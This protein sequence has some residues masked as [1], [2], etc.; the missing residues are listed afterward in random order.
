MSTFDAVIFD[1][2]GTLLDTERLFLDAALS[3]LAEQ[4]HDVGREFMLSLVGISDAEGA[5]RLSAR[6]GPRFDAVAFGAGWSLAARRAF[7]GGIPLM[8]GVAEFL[9]RLDGSAHPRAVATNSSTAGACFKLERAG[10]LHR[11][12]EAA[13]VGVDAVPLAKP[14]PDLFLE[15]ARRLDAEPSR[16][17]VFEDS[18]P[19]V[20]G[21]LAAGMTVVH[22]PDQTHPAASPAQHRAASLLEGARAAGLI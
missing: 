10:L 5:R 3:V 6:I 4:G 12:A 13:I 2:D 15:A 19:G 1:L 14:A 21:A 7:E 16:C 20:T 9:D 8:P 11:F 22:I 18:I 17:L